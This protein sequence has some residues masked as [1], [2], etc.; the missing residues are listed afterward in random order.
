MWRCQQ[1]GCLFGYQIDTYLPHKGHRTVVLVGE[2]KQWWIWTLELLWESPG[3]AKTEHI[4]LSAVLHSSQA[5]SQ[6]RDNS[7]PGN[8][9]AQRPSKQVQ[10][11]K[12]IEESSLNSVAWKRF[13]TLQVGLE[14]QNVGAFFATSQEWPKPIDFASGPVWLWMSS[15]FYSWE[16]TVKNRGH[17]PMLAKNKPNRRWPNCPTGY[18]PVTPARMQGGW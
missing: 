15:Q 5:Y 8:G 4:S 9:S 2:E 13:R 6:L 10:C 3:P 18:P 17:R 16:F 11:W 14:M 7:T 12:N 1:L